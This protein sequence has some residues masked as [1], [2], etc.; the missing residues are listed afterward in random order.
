MRSRHFEHDPEA[1]D[2]LETEETDGYDELPYRS[3]R[4]RPPIAEQDPIMAI[5]RRDVSDLRRRTLDRTR[6]FLERRDK[7]AEERPAVEQG[8]RFAEMAGGAIVAAFLAQRF[9]QAGGAIPLGILLGGIGYGAAHLRAFGRWSEDVKNA[10]LGAGLSSV[11][12]WAAG[13]GGLKEEQ[14]AFTTPQALPP[15]PAPQASLPGPVVSNV[16]PGVPS[17]S[18]APDAFEQLVARRSGGQP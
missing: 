7:H 4:S 17:G 3:A 10:S 6:A 11:V 9:R 14:M 8:L 18:P 2:L 5:S 1:D 16:M 12:L 15:V 13:L